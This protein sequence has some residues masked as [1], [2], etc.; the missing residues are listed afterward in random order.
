MSTGVKNGWVL[1]ILFVLFILYG[2]TLPYDLTTDSQVLRHNIDSI[3]WAP[4][5]RPDGSRE[6]I[7]DIVSNI[8]LFIP[9]GALLVLTIL[10]RRKRSSWPFLLGLALLGSALLSGLVET[11]QLFS[12]SRITSIT[13]LLTNIFGGFLGA[14]LL[15]VLLRVF[16]APRLQWSDRGK[17]PAP[18]LLILSVYVAVLFLSATIP[19]DISLDIGHIKSGFKAVRLDPF[20]DPTPPP[21]MLG[22]ALWLAGLS[23]LLCLALYRWKPFRRRHGGRLL[24]ALAALTGAA[25]YSVLME[26]LQ[27]FIGSRVAATRDVLAGLAGSVYGALWFLLLR[28]TLPAADGT[29][30]E[31]SM[32]ARDRA[33][34]YWLFVAHYLIFLVHGA[35]YP[36]VFERPQSLSRSVDAALVPFASYYGKTNALALFDFLGGILR[37]A[38]LGFLLQGRARGRR[39]SRK[40]FAVLICLL[41]GILLEGAQ[42]VVA[43]RYADSSDIIA[44]GCGGYVGWWVWRWWANRR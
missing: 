12:V 32:E 37:F 36:Y 8:L 6:S 28:P 31:A 35:L 21:K 17:I 10:Q 44:A 15:M 16:R 42:L 1:L 2:T 29:P 5:V 7:P 25:A 43:G 4:L 34:I 39:D 18:E 3:R 13:D 40:W 14:V 11:L 33:R 20:T 19:F 22:T 9:L 41:A 30:P 24:A 38:P 27:V 23:F 26:L